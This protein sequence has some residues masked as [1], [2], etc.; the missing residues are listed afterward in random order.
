[1]IKNQNQITATT[2]PKVLVRQLQPIK[3]EFLLFRFKGSDTFF[4]H[5]ARKLNCRTAYKGRGFRGPPHYG[6]MSK[7]KQRYIS[8][9]Y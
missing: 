2:L 8:K 9:N 4:S 3:I 1:M 6:C 7:N 5:I